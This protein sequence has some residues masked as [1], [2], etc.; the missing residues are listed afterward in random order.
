MEQDTPNYAGGFFSFFRG[1]RRSR[2]DPLPD[3]IQTFFVDGAVAETESPKAAEARA[4]SAP[5]VAAGAEAGVETSAEAGVEPSVEARGEPVLRATSVDL[6][7][8]ADMRLLEMQRNALALRDEAP[9]PEKA[10]ESPLPEPPKPAATGETAAGGLDYAYHDPLTLIPN[11]RAL[12]ERLS[13]A[14]ALA[15]RYDSNVGLVFIDVDNFKQVNDTRGHMIGD[16]VLMEIARRMKQAVRHGEIVGRFGGDEF[17]AVYPTITSSQELAD[18]ANRMLQVFAQPIIISGMSFGLSASIGVVMAPADGE[19]AKELFEHVDAAMY[20]AKSLG[21]S[22]VCWYSLEIDDELRTREEF[23]MRLNE[24]SIFG[25]LFLAFQPMYDVATDEIVAAEAL[26]RWQHPRRGLLNAQQIIDVVGVLPTP[27]EKWVIA[28]AIAHAAEWALAGAPLRVSVNVSDFGPQASVSLLEAL[29]A[30]KIDPSWFNV[31]IA[32]QHFAREREQV[33]TFARSCA[34]AKIGVSLDKFSG[35]VSIAELRQLPIGSLKLS[36]ALTHEIRADEKARSIVAATTHLAQSFGFDVI[37]TGIERADE[38]ARL[39]SMGVRIIQGYA[40]GLP[41][42][43]LDF[44]AW[45]L[46]ATADVPN[47]CA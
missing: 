28:K 5:Q 4:E 26:L 12:E 25:E 2:I 6:E 21:K 3:E 22:G 23:L 39:R 1:R 32:E 46:S 19:T 41:A 30:G 14:L 11:R 13:D 42:A 18:A 44:T 33:L 35:G 9:A 34:N 10:A 15:R 27:I 37:G 38:Y 45:L 16:A 47:H 31:E 40:K 7:P 17:A 24:P 8:N 29:E 36:A 43:A 20:R